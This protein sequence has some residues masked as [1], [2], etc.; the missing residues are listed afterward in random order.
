MF[1]DLEDN[2]LAYGGVEDGRFVISIRSEKL[3]PGLTEFRC[4]YSNSDSILGLCS[5]KKSYIFLLLDLHT[6]L[7]DRDC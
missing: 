2:D 6:K 5:K 1:L 4:K 3:T 7:T